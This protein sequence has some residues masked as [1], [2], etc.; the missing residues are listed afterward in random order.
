MS[1][2]YKQ[3][4]RRP[5][6]ETTNMSYERKSCTSYK[7]GNNKPYGNE[8]PYEESTHIPYRQEKRKHGLRPYMELHV[9]VEKS[10]SYGAEEKSYDAKEL[11][12][13]SKTPYRNT[14]LYVENPSSWYVRE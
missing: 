7:R 9:T 1:T 6:K 14:K 11:Y 13:N 2:P 12:W 8:R 4:W 3:V 5:C 10:S